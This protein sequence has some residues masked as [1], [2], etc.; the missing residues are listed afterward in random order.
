MLRILAF[1]TKIV[2]NHGSPWI[3]CHSLVFYELFW[4]FW[5]FDFL[6]NCIGM[7]TCSFQKIQEC[8]LTWVEIQAISLGNKNGKSH[9]LSPTI[10]MVVRFSFNNHNIWR[11]TDPLHWSQEQFWTGFCACSN[12]KESTYIKLLRE[13]AKF[14]ETLLVYFLF[15]WFESSRELKY[16]WLWR[17]AYFLEE[18]L[19]RTQL[20]TG[21]NRLALTGSSFL[22]V[23][24]IFLTTLSHDFLKKGSVNWIWPWSG[25]IL[26]IIKIQIFWF[27]F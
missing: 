3:C 19:W 7:C 14:S 6:S 25:I 15:H 12:A 2:N 22:H 11:Y 1:F 16:I 13:S 18:S 27:W 21:R 4:V 10:Q 20:T 17:Q 9:C 26:S 8:L 5:F 23:S 24:A